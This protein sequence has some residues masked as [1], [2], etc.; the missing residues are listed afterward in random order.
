MKIAAGAAAVATATPL[1]K[2]SNTLPLLR[3]L[4]P[5][6]IGAFETAQAETIVHGGCAPNCWSG[7]KL[8]VHVRDG[9]LVATE[10]GPL[11]DSRYDRICLRG[12][13]HVQRVYHPDRLRYPM[14]RV[15]ERGEGKWAR[16][17]WDEAINTICSTLTGIQQKYGNRAVAFHP[18][19]WLLRLPE[20]LLWIGSQ[21]R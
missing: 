9:K 5:S 6:S 16:I 13:T 11:P 18:R 10:R 12:L 14:K 21:I 2:Y 20:R 8:L 7:C 1:L 19:Q 15:G 17:S 4:S 3:A